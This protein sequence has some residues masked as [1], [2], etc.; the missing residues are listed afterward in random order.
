MC[1]EPCGPCTL[2]LDSAP[3]PCGHLVS[4]P[5]G[6]LPPCPRPCDQVL[7]CGHLCQERCGAPC[8]QQCRNLVTGAARSQCRHLAQVPCHLAGAEEGEVEVRAVSCE[9]PCGAV[10]GCG[11]V[12]AAA[13]HACAAGGGLHPPC[14]QPC[15]RQLVCGH[16]CPG[17]CG[18]L[19]PPCTRRCALGCPHGQCRARCGEECGRCREKCAWKCPHR[20]CTKKCYSKCSREV[21]EEKCS[22]VLGCG[23]QCSAR[24][25]ELCFCLQCCSRTAGGPGD[26]LALP[27]SCVVLRQDLE[28]QLQSDLVQLLLC[29]SCKTPIS[30]SF[31]FQESIRSKHE[32]VEKISDL[33]FSHNLK[34]SE[35]KKR[36]LENCLEDQ[37]PVPTNLKDP[38]TQVSSINLSM[39]ES[40]HEIYRILKSSNQE[41]LAS[42]IASFKTISVFTV[43]NLLNLLQSD[44]LAHIRR[45][46]EGIKL[47]SYE[48]GLWRKCS[49]CCDI[50][51][52]VCDKCA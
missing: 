48:I 44:N 11:H 15:A 51:Q 23:H 42:T 50:I 38:K 32:D 21:C 47:Y 26:Y 14:P 20:K 52:L 34:L 31:Q 18:A 6:S 13:C 46:I 35:R 1:H 7:G 22:L 49:S 39:M 12:C 16:T 25:G 43:K 5:C 8:T 10:L 30:H 28:R 29:P 40:I 36:L 24:C 2:W 33:F 9:E 3:L 37:F 45:R 4:G 17:T 19:C 27:C 41:K